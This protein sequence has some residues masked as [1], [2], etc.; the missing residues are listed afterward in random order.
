VVRWDAATDAGSGVAGYRIY[1]GPDPEGTSDWFS[2]LPEVAAPP[3]APGRYL[4]RIQA[5]D[6]AGNAGAW[7]TIGEMVVTE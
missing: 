4:L 5:L 2:A 1:I 3:L 6:Y 7:T